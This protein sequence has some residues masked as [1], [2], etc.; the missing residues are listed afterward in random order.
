MQGFKDSV[1]SMG[2]CGLSTSDTIN[3]MLVTQ[4]LDAMKEFSNGRA[5]VVPHVQG[6]GSALQDAVLQ[7]SDERIPP[8]EIL[9]AATRAFGKSPAQDIDEILEQI[10]WHQAQRTGSL[11]CI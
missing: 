1:D 10:E 7:D 9:A 2:E 3:M 6:S 8:Q 5:I 11:C 4:Y